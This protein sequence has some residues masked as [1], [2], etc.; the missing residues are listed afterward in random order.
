[1][2]NTNKQAIPTQGGTSNKHGFCLENKNLFKNL[3]KINSLTF[4]LS[5]T[6]IRIY[7]GYLGKT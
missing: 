1:M 5:T 7:L 6:H 4:Q 2:Y 3:K